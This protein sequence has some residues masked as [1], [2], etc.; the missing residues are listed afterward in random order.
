MKR[1]ARG[2]GVFVE[3]TDSKGADVRVQRSSASGEPA[4]WVFVKGGTTVS[5]KQRALAQECRDRQ[6]QMPG[7][8][9]VTDD[10]S[11]HLTR[12]QAR[13]LAR[14]LMRFSEVTR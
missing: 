2:F 14:A 7:D 1:T 3:F 6:F 8:E 9:L 4:V 12:A 13:R 10:T 5:A 11:A